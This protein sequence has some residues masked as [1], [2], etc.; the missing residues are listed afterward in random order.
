MELASPLK[1]RIKLK[2]GEDI[3]DDDI[4]AKLDDQPDI[5]SLYDNFIFDC[6]GVLWNGSVPIE[7]SLDVI[8][9]LLR[10]QTKKVFFL[11][12]DATGSRARALGKI[13]KILKDHMEDLSD[14]E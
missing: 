5:I 2:F 8:I 3:F 10:S 7:G 11:S 13:T 6:D 1:I 14:E 9:E 12:N 4:Q